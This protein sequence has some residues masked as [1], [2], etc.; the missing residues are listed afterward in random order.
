MAAIYKVPVG[1]SA[2]VVN[3][4]VPLPEQTAQ[5][6]LPISSPAII[7]RTQRIHHLTFGFFNLTF[8]QANRLL[9]AANHRQK[10]HA[11]TPRTRYGEGG[12]GR[13]MRRNGAQV[14]YAC[15]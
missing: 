12:Y 8:P 9:Y 13:R 10:L 15:L 7:D 4:A 5:L 1:P 2:G 6:R 14:P 3:R 11:V